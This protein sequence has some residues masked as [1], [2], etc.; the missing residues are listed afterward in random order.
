MTKM[1]LYH[2]G[3]KAVVVPEVT[4]PAGRRPLDFGSG[5]YATTSLE[6]AK[7]WVETR[8]RQ[9][10][11]RM[12]VVS[13]YEFDPRMLESQKLKVK[14]FRNA[15]G[16][17]FDFVMSNRHADGFT[18]DYD[19]VGGP[20]ANDNVYETLTLFED[21]ILT[22]EEAV[23]RLKAYK[24]ADQYLFHTGAALRLLRFAGTEEAK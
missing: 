16:E 7:R 10:V 15:D 19:I 22:K 2:G 18:H 24:L 14:L 13:R 12:G 9:K 23:V 8:V 5:F 6:Q 11:Y 3:E 20:V 4:S 1:L 21:G 17:W